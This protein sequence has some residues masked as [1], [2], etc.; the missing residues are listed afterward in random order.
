[1]RVAPALASG[2]PDLLCYYCKKRV[3]HVAIV[4]DVEVGVVWGGP[5]DV[6]PY[7][8]DYKQ[9]CRHCI[10]GR[11]ADAVL[12]DAWDDPTPMASAQRGLR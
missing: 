8:S 1:M 5:W 10:A 3:T 11:V 6:R 9:I 4:D 12:T 7:S 2:K